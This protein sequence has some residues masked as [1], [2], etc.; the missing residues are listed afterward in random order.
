MHACV[1]ALRREMECSR[2]RRASD[3]DQSYANRIGVVCL[4]LI[5]PLTEGKICVCVCV[6]VCQ[7]KLYPFPFFCKKKTK[8]TKKTF[9]T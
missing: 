1:Q 6:R 9:E 8:Q 7:A 4:V 3:S 2:L 5:W